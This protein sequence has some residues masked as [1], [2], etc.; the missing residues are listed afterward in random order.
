MHVPC[1]CAGDMIRTA[2]LENIYLHPVHGDPRS[3]PSMAQ[4]VDVTAH[5]AALVLC[6]PLWHRSAVAAPF[7]ATGAAA[8]G[9][10]GGGPGGSF[11]GQR[12]STSVQG[13]H[14]GTLADALRMD[15]AVLGVQLNIRMLLE[16]GAPACLGTHQ[17]CAHL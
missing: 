6:D 3:R 5:T 14:A 8:D 1:H 12:S 4:L 15:A 10:G 9:G 17:H 16:V 7:L 11:A 13:S 2:R